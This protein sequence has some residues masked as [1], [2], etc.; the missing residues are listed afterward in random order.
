MNVT[1]HS[2]KLLKPSIPTPN[3]LQKLNLSLLDQIQIPFYVGLIFHYETLSDNSDIT[4]SKLE[5]SLSETL[6]LYY[7]VAG[8]YNGT[9]CVI[10]CND[11][12]IGY[13]ETAF[14]VELHQFL[15]G[16]ESNNLDLLV[17]LSGF[18]SETETP[19]LAAIQL[20]MFKCGG[21]VI[22]AQFNHIIGDMF[23]MSTFMNSWAKACRVGIKEVAHPTFG[24]APLMPSAKVLN[25]PPPPSFEGVKFVSKRFV[26][27]ENA[28][29]RL[30]K[31]ATEEDGDGDDDQKKKRPSRVDLVTAFLSKSLIEMDCAKKEQ[32]KSRPSLMVHM[33][34]LRKRTKLALE[35]DVSGNFFIVVNAESKITVA[36]KITDLTES[37]GSACGEIISEVAKVDDAEVVSS[38]VLNSVR[39]F[40]YEW[41]KGEKNVFLYTSWCRF[42]LYEVDFGWGIPSLVD[43]TAVPFGLIVLMDEAP[44]GDGIAVRACL[45]E[46]DMIQFQQHHQL[47]SY[48][49]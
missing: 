22:G 42:P 1:M 40:Y 46:H 20:N 25:I 39:E 31:E 34:N 23:T 21:L 10:E 15:L 44:A 47:L 5:S 6:T 33:M 49:S 41:G 13:V 16:E 18:L 12:G 7:H 32:T 38:M 26:F 11:Q 36:P 19:P 4:L 29:T 9:D 43:T 30:R 28:I 35:N 8:R 37:L 48:V 24:L 45:S 27:N 17:G 14:D 3:H 2:K